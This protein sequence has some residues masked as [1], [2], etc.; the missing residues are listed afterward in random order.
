MAV[1][2][3]DLLP[4]PTIRC[5][6]CSVLV[7][8]G[9]GSRCLCCLEYRKTLNSMLHRHHSKAKDGDKAHPSSHTNYRFLNTPEKVERLHRLHQSVKVNRQQLHRLRARLEL[10]IQERGLEVDGELHHDLKD[11]MAENTT[12]VMATHPPD[13]FAHMFWEQQ[14]QA[15]AVKDARQM[16]WEP[17]MIRWCLYLRHLSTSAY[18]TIR[19]SG[20]VKLPSQRTLR[21]YTHFTQ[22]TTGF[23]AAVD[24]Q[25]M[26]E[27]M[28]ESCPD[29]EKSVVILM[30]EMHIKEGLVYNKHTGK[31]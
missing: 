30:D 21:D 4:F 5:T 20:A 22:A 10:I 27:A 17:M 11:I 18:E 31:N 1:Q 8:P 15:S 7:P 28:V 19:C 3:Q 9:A 14:R 13:S 12:M 23:S 2:E 26:D 16:R 29:H 6:T 25:L 24:K